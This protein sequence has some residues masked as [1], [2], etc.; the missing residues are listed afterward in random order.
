MPLKASG[1]NGVSGVSGVSEPALHRNR[2]PGHV[3]PESGLPAGWALAIRSAGI[4]P[5]QRGSTCN[6]RVHCFPLQVH[7]YSQQCGHAYAGPIRGRPSLPAVPL[8]VRVLAFSAALSTCRSLLSE[9]VGSG[10]GQARPGV[11]LTG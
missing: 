7:H 11:A 3:N 6:D 9:G 4:A 10:A 1:C 2:L 5:A 8:F